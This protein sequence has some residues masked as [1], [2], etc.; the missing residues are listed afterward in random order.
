MRIVTKQRIPSGVPSTSHGHASRLNNAKQ[1]SSAL[2]DFER[3][4][5]EI[6]G[7]DIVVRAEICQ[8]CG[9]R[10]GKGGLNPSSSMSINKNRR[11]PRDD[12]RHVAIKALPNRERAG[13]F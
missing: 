11:S 4:D 5:T 8:N 9:G 3:D 6:D 12:P 10:K 1:E 7:R 13:S 2:S